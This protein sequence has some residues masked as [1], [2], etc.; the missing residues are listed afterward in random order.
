VANKTRTAR[1]PAN[2]LKL[3]LVARPFPVSLWVAATSPLLHV[4]IGNTPALSGQAPSLAALRAFLHCTEAFACGFCEMWSIK[5]A[6][7]VE[8]ELEYCEPNGRPNR[9]PCSV[10]ARTTHGLVH[11]LR[12]HLDPSPLP[13]FNGLSIH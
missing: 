7:Y 3:L 13:G 9:I 5:E 12:F 4:R 10:I 6:I 11:D 2:A 1:F 8:T